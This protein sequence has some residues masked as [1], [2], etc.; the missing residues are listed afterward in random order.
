[1]A[2]STS[3]CM[4]TETRVDYFKEAKLVPPWHSKSKV[5]WCYFGFKEQGGNK[6]F[7]YC[8]LCKTKLKYC[9]NTT[10]LL[11]HFKSQHAL[12]Y[13]RRSYQ[14]SSHHRCHPN[15]LESL[16]QLLGREDRS[17]VVIPAR[18]QR[19]LRNTNIVLYT[20]GFAVYYIFGNDIHSK[21]CTAAC[22]LWRV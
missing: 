20:P 15:C 6:E 7:V 18:L 21:T 8:V 4:A 22:G 1:M 11:S 14:K 2:A 5:W 3:A 17:F 9:R 16:D 12:E 19:T 10:N 13:T